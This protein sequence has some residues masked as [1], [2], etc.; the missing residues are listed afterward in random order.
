MSNENELLSDLNENAVGSDKKT[1]LLRRPRTLG[2]ESLIGNA[3]ASSM[4]LYIKQKY[5][6]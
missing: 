3:E 6:Q 5:A 2:M 4:E 1:K